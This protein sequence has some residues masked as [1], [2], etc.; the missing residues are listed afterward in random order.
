MKKTLRHTKHDEAGFPVY[1]IGELAE[2]SIDFVINRHTGERPDFISYRETMRKKVADSLPENIHR[3]DNNRVVRGETRC[4]IDDW[5]NAH[6]EWQEGSRAFYRAN[7]DGLKQRLRSHSSNEN[8]SI[9]THHPSENDL[10]SAALGQ[11][12]GGTER[13]GPQGVKI[14][15]ENTI[16]VFEGEVEPIHESTSF[17]DLEFIDYH[18]TD[19][20]R[21]LCNATLKIIGRGKSS[22]ELDNH[23]ASR[24]FEELM[25]GLAMIGGV[26]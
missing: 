16:T 19:Q 8:D 4:T 7:I 2:A 6:R 20:I 10:K 14:P 22:S 12:Y 25:L 18:K 24:C 13:V 26:K 3:H 17:G 11:S 5:L 23:L 9:F 15:I 1:T 21:V